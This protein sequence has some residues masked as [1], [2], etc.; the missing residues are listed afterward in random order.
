ME[1]R[2]ASEVECDLDE[3][4]CYIAKGSGIMEVADRLVDSITDRF[5][6]LAAHP[7]MGR[8]RDADLRPGL[9]SFA[10]GEYVII[11]RF[12]QEAVVILRV[13]HGNRN[14]QAVLRG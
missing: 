13:I 14:I 11:Y 10:V 3:I 7:H 5:P 4:W 9:R 1:H 8:A 6:L 2:R 12:E